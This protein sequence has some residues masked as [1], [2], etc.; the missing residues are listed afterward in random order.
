MT[1]NCMKRREMGKKKVDLHLN[2]KIQFDLSKIGQGHQ[3][4]NSCDIFPL[5][6][7][8]PKR[9]RLGRFS[10]KLSRGDDQIQHVDLDLTLKNEV[11]VTGVRTR[12]TSFQC[13]PVNQSA[14]G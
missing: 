13:A 3:G 9:K 2:A 7:C 6:T 14:V 5:C 8:I 11:K 1:P 4:S 10:V 12:A